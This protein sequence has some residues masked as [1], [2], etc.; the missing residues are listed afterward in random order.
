MP[1]LRRFGPLLAALLLLAC[2][3]GGGGSEPAPALRPG[4]LAISASPRLEPWPAT[5]Q[6]YLDATSQAT[7]L[8]QDAGARG[9]MSTWTWKA[10]EPTAGQ[11]DAQKLAELDAAVA[12]ATSRGLVLY[13]GLQLIN[14]SVLEL[15]AGLSDTAFDG[16]VLQNRFKAL[17]D[18]VITPHRGRIRYLSIGNEV[19]AWLRANPAQW[20]RYRSFFAAMVAYAHQLDPAIQVGV[21]GTADAALVQS[22]AELRALNA[23]ADVVILTYYPLTFSA[24]GVTVRNPQQVVAADFA[25]MRGFAV[26][27]PLV[28]Q[29][30][31]F[32]AAAGNGSSQAL[33]SAFVSQVFAAWRQPGAAPIPF[34]NFF[35]LHDFTPQMCA[36]FGVYYGAAGQQSFIDFL[37]SLGLRQAD[38]TPRAAWAVLQAEARAA[39]LP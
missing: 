24:S 9:Q 26:G 37:C 25:A 4:V 16:S 2:G 3:G 11:Y 14:T 32:P 21:T 36:D 8:V 27:K 33:Q 34:L 1:A 7:Q 17:L 22:A 10:L 35:L 31:G 18:R 23:A 29:E 30:V 38:G 15:P 5:P 13:V 28:L 19:D 39:G 20:P 12:G 6:A